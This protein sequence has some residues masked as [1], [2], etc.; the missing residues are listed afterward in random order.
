MVVN[1]VLCELVRKGFSAEGMLQREPGGSLAKGRVSA[2][3]LRLKRFQ[4]EPGGQWDGSEW[5]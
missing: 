1:T 2:K 4:E 5:R 3:A